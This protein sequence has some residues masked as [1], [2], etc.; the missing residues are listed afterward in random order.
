MSLL[1]HLIFDV[2]FA[3]LATLNGLLV[4]TVLSSSIKLWPTRSAF[5]D[6]GCDASAVPG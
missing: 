1:A 3:A 2:A 6:P 5:C 4:L